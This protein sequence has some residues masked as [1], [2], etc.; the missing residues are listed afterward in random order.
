MIQAVCFV[1]VTGFG[2]LGRGAPAGAS[3]AWSHEVPSLRVQEAHGDGT[4]K[5]CRVCS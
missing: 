1:Q 5:G 3:F 2:A 4:M